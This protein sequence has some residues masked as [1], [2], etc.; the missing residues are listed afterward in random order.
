MNTEKILNVSF[1]DELVI[2]FWPFNL[3]GIL[4]TFRNLMENV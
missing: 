2:F 1:Y 3:L 4:T